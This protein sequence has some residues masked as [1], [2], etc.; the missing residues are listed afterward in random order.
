[1]GSGQTSNFKDEA[2]CGRVGLAGAAIS[3]LVRESTCEMGIAGRS[4]LCAQ[5]AAS[6]RCCVV[7]CSHRRLEGLQ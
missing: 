5:E 4:K 3:L 1:M 6:T 2:T 7:D